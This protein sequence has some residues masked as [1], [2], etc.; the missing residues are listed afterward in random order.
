MRIIYLLLFCLLAIRVNAQTGVQGTIKNRQNE[1]LPFSTIY[2]KGT[3]NGTTANSSAIYFLKTPP[4][5]HT[6]V[7]Q[8]LG[9]SIGEQEVVIEEGQTLTLDFVLDEQALQLETVT[10]TANEEDPAYRIVR[11]AIKKR[12]FYEHEVEAF[13]TDVYLKGLFRLENRPDK[14]LG[15]T[16]TIDT[17]I[18]YLSE[19]VSEFSFER[20]DK[21]K[22]RMIS[23]KVSGDEQGFSFNQAS[24]FNINAYQKTIDI[25][26]ERVF[27]SPI[28]GQAFLFYDYEWMGIFEEN[29]KLV[30]KIKL[31][32]KRDS[33]PAFEGTIYIIEDE[34]RFYALDLL[35]TKKRGIE[36]IDSLQIH[37]VFAPT[38]HDIWMPLSQ[39]FAFQFGAFGFKGSGYYIGVYSNYEIEPNYDLYKE[40]GEYQQKF[41]PAEEK[42]L[43]EEADFTA[44]VLH[45]EEGSNERDSTYWKNIRPVPLTEIEVRDY[46]EKD[47]VRLVKESTPYKDSMDRK[48]NKVTIGNVLLSGYAHYNSIDEKY[49]T[50]P[51]MI[52]MIQFNTVEG[53]VIELQPTLYKQQDERTTH[54]IRPSL[55]YGFASEE[56]Y[57]KI[58]VTR[59]W[60][61]N[62]FT[63]LHFGGG[64]YVAQFDEENG[65]INPFVNTMTTLSDGNNFMK[66]F[67]KSFA[68]TQFGQ[69]LV[70]GIWM[71]SRIEYAARDTLTNTKTDYYWAPTK[72]VNFTSNQPFNE[73]LDHDT[74]R[75]TIANLA[76]NRAFTASLT[77]RFRFKQQYAT[78][79]GR[80]FIYRSKYPEFFLSYKKGFADIDYDFVSL[81]IEDQVP[82]GLV[83]TSYYSAEAGAFLNN[84]AMTFVDYKH[85]AGNQTIFSQSSS[86]SNRFE[87]L[88]FYQFSTNDSYVK[89]HYEHHF[90]E[91]ILN[92]LP[93]VR[94]LNLQAVATCNYLSTETLGHYVELGVGIEHIFK[95][96]RVDFYQA[97]RNGA[98]FSD[99]VRIGIGF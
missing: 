54:W 5:K 90:N 2:V 61:N 36:F 46:I 98:F 55:R 56:P 42:D 45:I 84:S 49:W 62:K 37:Q 73:E 12:K 59:R 69:E 3:T 16:V 44:E 74:D 88:P 64:K 87:L 50:L 32:P 33:D 78:Q 31:L 94:Q 75:Q 41:D 60:L 89:A 38:E 79:P 35:L 80:K 86:Q 48:R 26:M 97:I 28:S 18:I 53:A 23:S 72:E 66:L 25:D 47:S 63:R 83:G 71:N 67:E 11:E 24:D 95:F 29:G 39:R 93:L 6:I 82:F 85:F 76:A 21:V 68:Y 20:P 43:F 99:G 65:G 10:I 40:E 81:R 14:I 92:K 17:G 91:F 27:V 30:N 51:P 4:G 8:H 22:E 96:M 1:L 15:Q 7:V 9:Y 70:N 57:G 77:F 19:S 34:W 58:E 52:G 13:K